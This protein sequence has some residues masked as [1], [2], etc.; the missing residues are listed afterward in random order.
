M[1][2]LSLKRGMLSLVYCLQLCIFTWTYV[3]GSQGW[4]EIWQLQQENNKL[5]QL[6]TK[7][8]LDIMNLERELVSWHDQSFYKEKIAREQLQMARKGDELFYIG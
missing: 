5:S 2:E 7:A 6:V 4:C 1:V 3:Y 8:Q